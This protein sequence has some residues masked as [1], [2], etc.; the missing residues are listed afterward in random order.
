MFMMMGFVGVTA[1]LW[2]IK[3]MYGSIVIEEGDDVMS[4]QAAIEISAPESNSLI[5]SGHCSST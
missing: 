1:S 5:T 4:Y 2:F 3:T